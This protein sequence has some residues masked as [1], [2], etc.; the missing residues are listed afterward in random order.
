[1]QLRESIMKPNNHLLKQ[2]FSGSLNSALLR[3]QWAHPYCGRVPSVHYILMSQLV[4]KLSLKTPSHKTDSLS[5]VT[6]SLK[7]KEERTKSNVSFIK[8]TKPKRQKKAFQIFHRT[9][10]YYFCAKVYGAVIAH[11]KEKM[12]TKLCWI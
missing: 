5:K 4:P 12:L 11:S 1:M 6:L 8:L 10:V 3:R 2:S 7:V 9:A